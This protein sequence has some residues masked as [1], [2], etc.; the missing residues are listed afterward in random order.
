MIEIVD[1]EDKLIANTF[2]SL[3][4]QC[5]NSTQGIGIWRSNV[6]SREVILQR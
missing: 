4:I 1:N 5:F 6:Q 3:S 2:I